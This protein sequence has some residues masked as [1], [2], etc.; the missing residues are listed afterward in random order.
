MNYPYIYNMKKIVYLHG[1]DALPGEKSD[2]LKT[3]YD[4]YSPNINY[5]EKNIFNDIYNNIKDKDIDYI[6]G[7]SMGGYFAFI[8]GNILNVDVILLNPALHN[9][10]INI[11]VPSFKYK[12][13][14][15]NI[16][17]GQDDVDVDPF[18]TTNYLSKLNINYDLILKSNIGHRVDI[19][20]FKNYVDNII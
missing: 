16:L 10:S 12:D 13:I 3:K 11:D 19:D 1:L 15:Y 5:R 8:L 20:T 9:R 14:K 4:V 2:Y 6:I 17:L 18:K 7:S